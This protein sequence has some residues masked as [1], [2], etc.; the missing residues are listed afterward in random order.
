M[1]DYIL[2]PDLACM[3]MADHTETDSLYSY[4]E[5]AH[6][7]NI[8]NKKEFG[9]YPCTLYLKCPPEYQAHTQNT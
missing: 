4:I 9:G 6:N 2:P 8:P 7:R 3:Y 1:N 5:S